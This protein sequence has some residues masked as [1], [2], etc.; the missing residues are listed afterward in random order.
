M[1]V[2]RSDSVISFLEEIV[3]L[4]DTWESR[5]NLKEYRDLWFRGVPDRSYRLLPRAYRDALD[6]ESHFLTFKSLV[7]SLLLRQPTDDWEWYT[8]AQHYGLPTRLLDW[9]E[10]PL[11]ALWFA[12]EKCVG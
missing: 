6:E 3:S 1:E 10:S 9:T 8:L 4:R 2:R 5:D 12:T 7:P 11:A